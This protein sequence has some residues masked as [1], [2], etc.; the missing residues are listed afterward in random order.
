MKI[1]INL[2]NKEN[3]LERYL[4]AWALPSIAVGVAGLVLFLSS[5]AQSFVELR[6]VQQAARQMQSELT[7]LRD[8]QLKARRSLEQPLTLNLYRETAFVNS[9]IDEKQLS[10]SRITVRTV[11]LLPPGTR[12]TSLSVTQRAKHPVVSMIVQ[13]LS[14]D[15][16]YNFL[17]QLEQSPDFSG[18]VV[19]SQTFTPQPGKDHPVALT[20]TATYG[21]DMLKKAGENGN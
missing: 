9:L 1:S 14:V 10:L 16:L 12:L 7:L 3:P 15:S 5:A 17:D 8:R 11:E 13:G 2:A 19:T 18:V 6:K 20:C 4:L 21:S